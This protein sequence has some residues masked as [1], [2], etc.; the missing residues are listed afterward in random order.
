MDLTVGYLGIRLRV[1]AAGIAVILCGLAVRAIWDPVA[2]WDFVRDL[3]TAFLG[4]RRLCP[5]V[6]TCVA[7]W[8]A[9]LWGR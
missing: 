9:T 4:P 5:P 1:S 7:P 6:P 8:Y 2:A 3:V